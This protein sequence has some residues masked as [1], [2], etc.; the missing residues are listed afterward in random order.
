MG[1]RHISNLYKNN[2]IQIFRQCYALEKIDGTS[3]HITYKYGKLSYF[4]GC[5]NHEAF[6]ALFNEAELLAKF[7]EMQMSDITVFGEAYGGKIQGMSNTYG[8]D[9]KFVAFEVLLSNEFAIHGDR[10]MDVPTAHRMVER[11][12]LEFVAYELISTDQDALDAARD[13]PSRQAIRNGLG[14][15]IAEGVVLRPIYEMMDAHR[16]RIICKHKRPEFSERKSKADTKSG[17]KHQILAE[18]R[19]IA[20]EWVTEQRLAHVKDALVGSLQRELTRADIPALIDA[21]I[22]DVVRESEGEIVEGRLWRKAVGNVTAEMFRK[23]LSDSE[24]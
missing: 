12:G 18:A 23:S 2:V 19:E 15:H 1:Y 14:E 21:M 16:G 6:K 5:A 7:Q 13:R 4:S 20:D 22:A 10:W 8:K 9:L 24:C 3:A 11:L 17:E